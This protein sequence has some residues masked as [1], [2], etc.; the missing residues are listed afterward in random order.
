MEDSL[1]VTAIESAEIHPETR[2]EYARKFSEFRR[3]LIANRP[4]CCHDNEIEW[5]EVDSADFK[6]FLVWVRNGEKKPDAKS[7]GV[8][9]S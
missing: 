3:W 4:S 9:N 8:R 7:L 5:R 2:R 1:N 6:T